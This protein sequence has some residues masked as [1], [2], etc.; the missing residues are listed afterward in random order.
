MASA[1]G[2]V[3]QNWQSYIEA[4]VTSQSDT[5]ATITLKVYF[6]SRAYGFKTFA[7]ADGTINGVKSAVANFSATSGTGQTVNQLAVTHTVTVNKGSSA[8]NIS[9]SGRVQLTGGFQ[10][11]TS[12]AYASVSIP[13]RTYYQPHPPKN[14]AAKR[15]SDTQ[16]DLTWQG[17]YTGM[18]GGYPWTG[19][20]VDRRV[21]DGSWVNIATLSWSAVN[22]SDKTTTGN[23]KYEYRVCSYGPGGTSDH[24]TADALYTTPAAPNSVTM[25]KTSGTSVRVAVD[26]SNAPYATS[27]EVQESLNGGDW[28]SVGEYDSFPVSIDVGG[29]TAKLRARSK[30]DSLLSGWT[31]SATI[32]TIVAPNA[33]TLT[34]KPAAVIPIGEMMVVS[35]EPNHPDGSEQTAAQVGWTIGDDPEEIDDI[36]GDITFSSYRASFTGTVKIRVRTKGIA[37]DWGAWTSYYTVTVAVPPEAHF[38]TPGIDG[39]KIGD[40]PLVVE[41]SITDSTGVAS[42]NLQLMDESGKVLHSATPS[43]GTRQYTL[44]ASTYQLSNATKYSLRLTVRGGSSLTVTTDRT[45]STSF[46]EPAKP[47]VSVH[48]DEE[49]LSQ[50]VTVKAGD[51]YS[52]EAEVLTVDATAGTLVPGFSIFGRTRQNLWINPNVTIGG[53]TA[54]SNDDGSVTISGTATTPQETYIQNNSYALVPGKAYTLSVDALISSSLDYG[55]YFCVIELD[56]SSKEITR[57]TVGEES[58]STTFTTKENLSQS[59]LRLRVTNGATVSGTYRVMLR[60]AT[61]DEIAAAQQMPTTLQ[62]GGTADLP[63]NYP[64]TLPTDPI[65]YA[66]NDDF[67]W[68]PPGIN[69]VQPTALM[70]AG[71]NLW[72]NP[73]GTSNGITVT[74][75]GDGTIS[76]SGTA[77]ARSVV[78][79]TVYYL[80]PGRRYALS[81]DRKIADSYSAN[82]DGACIL[83]ECYGPSGWL[84]N[85]ILGYGDVLSATLDVPN[86]TTRAVFD[87]LV[88]QGESVSGTYR[89]MLSYGDT[90]ETWV[91]PVTP[92]ST[93]IDMQGNELYSLPDGTRDVMSVDATGKVTITK[94]VGVD[95]IPTGTSDVS[96]QSDRNRITFSLGNRTVSGT[97]IG[98]QL[99]SET[100]PPAETGWDKPDNSYFLATGTT[101]AVKLNGSTSASDTVSKAG[102][103]LVLYPLESP[104]TIELD[105]SVVMPEFPADPTT[106]WAVSD[107]PGT[108]RV[109]YPD[110]D[111]LSVTRVLADGSRWLVDDGLTSGQQAI[112]PLPPL[113]TDYAYEVTAHTDAGALVST[114]APQRIDS[115][116]RM[117]LNFGTAASVAHV[118]GANAKVS[119]DESADGELYHFADGGESG[120][121]PQFYGTGDIDASGSVSFELMDRAERDRFKRSA[122]RYA[123]GWFRDAMGGRIRAR[124]GYSESVSAGGIAVWEESVDMDEVIFEEAW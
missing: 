57:H 46:A 114:E 38:T 28:T 18:D 10:N 70:T 43:T 16:M 32:T 115:R 105:G 117:A 84:K 22:Y 55:S 123:V 29:G 47:V 21:D 41:W 92:T 19:V 67:D 2:N 77:T 48:L 53:I 62:E 20:Y 81:I 14:F 112:D 122:R 93:A 124:M 102:G 78:S 8:Q 88:N 34:T 50:A 100:V 63:Q 35:W 37:E 36:T 121:L 103:G 1:Y 106:M 116:G 82:K 39:A 31:E 27:W 59:L 89:I 40:L 17:D 119:Y 30:R 96:W 87:V 45:F 68:C 110:T 74:A 104:Q 6:H 24:A 52:E 94:N 54:T 75:N 60:E 71:K 58:L 64:V 51:P 118:M 79:Q 95:T 97:V 86:E 5:T 69:G 113:N 90:Q 91:P 4:S 85:T 56:S 12:T 109:D 76:L 111:S 73:N 15:T 44:D 25:T 99:M 61:E 72:Q 80:I 11:G 49:A 66:T 108:V 101:G 13:A 98:D 42:Q 120:G 23:H 107:V 33:P 9:V 83:V 26:G 65:V 3:V 7:N